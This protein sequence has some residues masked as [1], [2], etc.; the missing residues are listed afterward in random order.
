MR[1]LEP[2]PA[3]R[4]I[5]TDR[6]DVCALEVAGYLT[7]ADLENVYGLLQAAYANHEK[8]DLLVRLSGYDGFDWRAVFTAST[9]R[10]ERQALR[11]I[12]KYALVAAPGWMR[13]MLSTFSPLT[14]IES[15][16]FEA[17]EEDAAWAW[18]GARPVD[19]E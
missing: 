14:S 6:S 2:V 12:R 13:I 4:R 3:I 8:V 11:H 18:L 1:P 19:Q 7:A 17:A 9:L 15:R 16:N 5:E 10:G